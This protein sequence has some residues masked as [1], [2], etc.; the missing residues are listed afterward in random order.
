[1]GVW[2]LASGSIAAAL[3]AFPDAKVLLFDYSNVPARFKVKYPGGTTNVEL[4]N[5]RYSKR[6]FLRNNI[7]WLIVTAL[8]L[9]LVPS[10]RMKAK[11][12]D[13]NPWLRVITQAEIV[14]SIAG[15]DSF[16]DIYG[17]GRL[18][19]VS[20]PQILT[21]LLGRP[22]I[23]MPQTLGPFRSV[24]AK[25]LARYILKHAETVYARDRES[26]LAVRRLLGKDHGRLRFCYDM[27]F[28]LEPEIPKERIPL[29]LVEN[30]N[31][32]PLVGLNVSGLLYIG[33]Y[34]QRNMF[35]LKADYRRVIHD[36]IDYFVRKHNARVMLVPHV[37]GERENIESDLTAC[38]EIYSTTAGELRAHLHL[39]E[40]DYD[41]QELKALIGSCDFFLGSRMHACI[42]A[43][44]QS[45]PAM[46]LAYSRK[47][48]GVFASIGMEDAVIDLRE[49]DHT[50]IIEVVDRAYER[51][52]ELRAKL[53]SK[54]PAVRARVLDLFVRSP[55][56]INEL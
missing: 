29:W 40:E 24:W 56:D 50:S 49:H 17:L 31:R 6:I 10:R 42:A 35:G 27:G 15:G 19:Y 23:V 41:H 39:L 55:V 3:H 37:L 1:M 48:M 25:A 47:F 5:I 7:V 54:I 20:L 28:V 33:G 51:R 43:L 11:I 34:T 4:V 18:I 8:F 46:G 26:L 44:S 12:L 2:A 9:K 30:D 36:L 45:V 21:L 13:G 53:E 52:L 14:G 32:D 38:R 22:L 16:S